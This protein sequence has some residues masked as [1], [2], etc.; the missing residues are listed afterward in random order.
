MKYGYIGDLRKLA[1][2]A[3]LVVLKGRTHKVWMALTSLVAKGLS[4]G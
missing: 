3:G 1:E 4:R 2:E